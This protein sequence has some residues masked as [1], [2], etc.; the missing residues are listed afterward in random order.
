MNG[1]LFILVVLLAISFFFSGCAGTEPVPPKLPGVLRA[2]GKLPEVEALKTEQPENE[3]ANISLRQDESSPG[4]PN[5]CEPFVTVS[6]EGKTTTYYAVRYMKHD[7]MI[8]QCN[9]WRECCIAAER[10]DIEK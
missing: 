4:G 9:G 7:W 6:V 2:K 10:R 5:E 1:C 3:P 8:S